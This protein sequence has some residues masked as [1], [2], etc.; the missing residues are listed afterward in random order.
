MKIPQGNSLYSY[1]YLKEAKMSGFFF[2]CVFKIF[3]LLQNQR[4]TGQNRCCPVRRAGT[5]AS[6]EVAGKGGRRVNTA[7][8]MCTYSCKCK[9]M[10]P[11]E[12]IL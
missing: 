4:T 3:S 6:G 9:K 8:K 12:T 7:Q 1:R 2:V 11:V 10:I 5:S